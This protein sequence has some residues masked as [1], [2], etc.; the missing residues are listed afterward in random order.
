MAITTEV[1]ERLDA[2]TTNLFAPEDDALRWIQ[3]EAARLALPSISIR[4]H[5]GLLLHLL[6]VSIGARRAVEIGTLAGY[7][8]VWIARALPPD[9]RLITLEKSAKHAALARQS[10][11]RAGVADR[12]ELRE[13]DALPALAR[14]SAEGPF[15]FVFI[16]ADKANYTAYYAWAADHLRPGG[17]MA[18]HNA[19]R[20]GRVLAPVDDDDRAVDAFNRQLA[21][22]DRFVGGILGVG[23]GM[24][25]GIR[26]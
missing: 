6:I 5:E 9:G 26:R 19:F 18:A 14:L 8:A 12:V 25:V 10:F 11:A 24:S 7:S 17:I 22:D 13:G 20:G 23:D 15:D 2:Y 1:R 4:P 16:D 3:T 21:A